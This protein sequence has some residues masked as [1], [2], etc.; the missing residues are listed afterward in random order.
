MDDL[1]Q[2]SFC[3]FNLLN[4]NIPGR[5]IYKDPGWTDE[6]YTKKLAWIAQ[7]LQTIDAD[8]FGFQELWHAEAL[9]DAFK[10]A[11]LLDAYDLVTPPSATGGKIV[12]A[13]AVRK[14]LRIG[15]AEWIEDF[16]EQFILA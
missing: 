8:V 16:P 10:H 12:C 13:A 2:L 3:T 4:L 14:G 9:Q 7:Q 6:Q 15:E 5:P 11:G 1:K